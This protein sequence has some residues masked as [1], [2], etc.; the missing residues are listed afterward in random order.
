MYYL[1]FEIVSSCWL[2]IVILSLLDWCDANPIIHE[3][4]LD[5]DKG[6]D[7]NFDDETEWDE[8]DPLT[9]DEYRRQA[10]YVLK[11]L[12]K[13]NDSCFKRVICEIA[14]Y[15]EAYSKIGSDLIHMLS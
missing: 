14:V 5:Q 15:P 4:R 6:N 10:F 12:V 7:Y 1:R 8:A 3:N 11:S 2:G 9:E 13:M